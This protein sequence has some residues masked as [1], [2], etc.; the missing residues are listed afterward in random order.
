MR[1]W[2]IVPL[3]LLASC[4]GG[5]EKKAE[6]AVPTTLPAGQWETDF[7]VTKFASADKTT[8]AFDAKVGDKETTPACI[9][10]GATEPPA[11]LFAGEGYEC[12]Y[13]SNYVRN[14]RINASLN[15][16]REGVIGDIMMSVDGSFK[17]DSFE[18]TVST[19]TYLPGDGDFAM[20]RK[21]KGRKT[22][23]ACAPA[24]AEPAPKAG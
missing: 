19:T 18:G 4:S 22:G 21:L 14:G 3:C 15:C 11:G 9:P 24:P 12:T 7:E 17:A 8:P 6:E 20:D 1:G 5:E 16:K 13:K 2:M 10:A 23:E